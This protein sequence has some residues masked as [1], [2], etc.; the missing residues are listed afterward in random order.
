MLTGKR[1]FVGETVSETLAALLTADVDLDPLP[2][3]VPPAGRRLLRRCFEKAPT[4]R[5]RELTEDSSRSRK[6]WRNGLASHGPGATSGCHSG[7]P[8]RLDRRGRGD[9]RSLGSYQMATR[10]GP[11]LSPSPPPWSSRSGLSFSARTLPSCTER[12]W[13]A[14]AT[15]TISM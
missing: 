5:L 1:T 7:S 13:M 15:R 3:D 14:M 4:K 2:T 11:F 9:R 6:S 12:I 10:R 8:G